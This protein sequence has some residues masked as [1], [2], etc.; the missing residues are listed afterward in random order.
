MSARTRLVIVDDHPIVLLGL[1]NL[2]AAEPDF[3]LIAEANS[4]AAGLH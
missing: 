1:R 3:D 4:G 2:V